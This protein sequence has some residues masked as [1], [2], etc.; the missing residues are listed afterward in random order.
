MPRYS[1]K[2]RNDLNIIVIHPVLPSA[3]TIP[4]KAD[5]V[6]IAIDLDLESIDSIYSSTQLN[7]SIFDATSILLSL[8]ENKNSAR[9]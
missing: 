1:A 6:I 5:Y 7:H 8:E 9:G 4:E 3:F 2:I